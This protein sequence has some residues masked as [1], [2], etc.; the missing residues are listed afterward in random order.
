MVVLSYPVSQCTTLR[1]AE[2]TCW[3][4]R[5]FI[6]NRLSGVM[7][8]CDGSDKGK[9]AHFVHVSE[10]LRRILWLR[11]DKRSG[12]KV[13]AVRGKCNITE[14]DKGE[15]G[16]EQSQEHPH[17]ILWYQ[18]DSSQIIRPGRPKCQFCMQL[19]RFMANAWKCA[20]TS[21]RTLATKE[22]A[23]ASR[24]RVSFHHGYFFTKDKITVSRPAPTR[25]TW[26]LATF[27]FPRLKMKPKDCHFDT[28]EVI[29]AESQMVL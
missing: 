11:L 1:G 15:T 9:A 27:L 22:L 18:G 26:P 28:V 21:P 8:F 17:T 2:W 19:W 12:K 24:Q 7:Q 20:K 10:K 13:W 23:V 6:W 3:F 5:P 16:E 25:L 14:T 4:L 29:E